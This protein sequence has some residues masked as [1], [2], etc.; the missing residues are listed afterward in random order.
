MSEATGLGLAI[1]K[2]LVE[3][4][5]GTIT[6][7]SRVGEGSVFRFTLPVANPQRTKAGAVLAR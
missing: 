4:Q 3:A 2:Q 6:A 5:G 7:E 1:V